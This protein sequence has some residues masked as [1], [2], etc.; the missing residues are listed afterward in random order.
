MDLFCPY[1]QIGIDYQQ[2]KNR[3]CNNCWHEWD[4]YHVLPNNDIKNHTESYSCS[5][6]PEIQTE[7]GNVIIVHNSFDGREG[8]EWTNEILNNDDSR[9][10]P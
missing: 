2:M 5:C 1:C 8:V 7:N 6:H 4:T 3:K 9:T 10:E